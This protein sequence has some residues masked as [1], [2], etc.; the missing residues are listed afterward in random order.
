MIRWSHK[1]HSLSQKYYIIIVYV[2]Y[3]NGKYFNLEVV[4]LANQFQ[5]PTSSKQINFIK[6]T[7]SSELDEQEK[8]LNELYEWMVVVGVRV[9]HIAGERPDETWLI[10]RGM[11]PTRS[12]SISCPTKVYFLSKEC[13]RKEPL[14][15][16]HMF[17]GGTKDTFPVNNS[18][19]IW[20][21]ATLSWSVTDWNFLWDQFYA[22]NIV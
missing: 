4:D 5:N 17:Q 1:C 14:P 20:H 21:A 9:G 11:A 10:T 7:L 12:I 2:D 19:D 8:F 15:I 3:L 6:K 18:S 13:D 16:G 22:P